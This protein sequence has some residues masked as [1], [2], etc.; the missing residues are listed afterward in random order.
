MSNWNANVPVYVDGV[1]EVEAETL[2]AVNSALAGR[3]QY[4]FEMLS[5]QSD[6]TVLLSYNQ[7]MGAI[8]APGTPVFFDTSSG[9][10]VL[11]PAKSGYK[12]EPAERLAPEQSAFVFGIVKQIYEGQPQ[13]PT[14]EVPAYGDIYIRGLIQDDNIDFSVILDSTSLESISTLTPCPLYLSAAEPGKLTIYP[15]G[16]AIF[17]G[18]YIGNNSLV[19]APNIDSLNQLYFNHRLFLRPACAGS[20]KDNLDGTFTIDHEGSSASADMATMVGWVSATDANSVLGIT[21]PA[22]AKFYYNV[23]SDAE[24]ENAPTHDDDPT[25]YYLSDTERQDAKLLKKALPAHPAAYTMVFMNGV[26]Q[27]ECNED[28]AAGSYKITSD[29][30]WWMLNEVSEN[31]RYVPWS[32]DAEEVNI[33]LII[34]KLNPDFSS[35]LVTSL[36]STSPAIRIIGNKGQD[37]TSGDL[38]IKLML[39]I[40]PVNVTGSGWA[41]Q[42]L[43]FDYQTGITTPQITPVINTISAGP[44]LSC[45]QSDGKAVITLSSYILGGEVT[46]IEPEECD[47]VF[48]GLHSYLRIKDPVV[49]QRIGFVGKFRIPN[50]IPSGIPL[51]IKLDCFA[52]VASSTGLSNLATFVFE[53][54]ISNDLTSLSTAKTSITVP[55]ILGSYFHPVV[56]GNPTYLTQTTLYKTTGGIPFF[57]IPSTNYSGGAYINFRIARTKI[58]N[59]STYS[60]PLG[61]LGV[62]WVIE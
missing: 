7:P 12:S 23:P 32:D 6:K 17:I 31:G 43:G 54:A 52:D 62:N 5:G 35:T 29:G 61:I 15:S 44:G 21:I 13:N 48:K 4:L 42:D 40:V 8:M 45:T 3:D 28:H 49:N 46:D 56:S 2:N 55:P 51:S 26:L 14:P 38:Q 57:T 19:L 9:H 47:F 25:G 22:G 50:N 36:D 37:S 59:T 41:V 39:P 27:N 33:Q 10:A 18:Y 60:H 58:T 53:Y 16:A 1:S 34:T 20:P 30:I 24:I 11:K